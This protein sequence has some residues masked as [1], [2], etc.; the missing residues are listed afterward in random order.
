MNGYETSNPLPPA[1]TAVALGSTNPSSFGRSL[2]SGDSQEEGYPPP[3]RSRSGPRL[4]LYR[5]LGL[6]LSFA[7]RLAQV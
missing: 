2:R 7:R 6:A 1:P 3:H 4:A 5:P